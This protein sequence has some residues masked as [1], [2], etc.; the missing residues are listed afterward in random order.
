MK[1]KQQ[2]GEEAQLKGKVPIRGRPYSMLQS[3]L[4]QK[5]KSLS[6]TG[7]QNQ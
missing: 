2:A 1:E 6:I 7:F 5:F 4:Q 3:V